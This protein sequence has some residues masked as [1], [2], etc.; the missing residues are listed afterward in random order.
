MKTFE[1]V[2]ISF[3][4]IATRIEKIWLQQ[5]SETKTIK[6]VNWTGPALTPEDAMI[7]ARDIADRI[8][9][10]AAEDSEEKDPTKAE[11]DGFW[12]AMADQANLVDFANFPNDVPSV[13]QSTFDFLLY[14]N[15]YLPTRPADVN[16]AK[17]KSKPYVPREL[18]RKIDSLEKRIANLTPRSEALDEKIHAIEAAHD[19]AEQL[20]TDMEELRRNN[21]ELRKLLGEAQKSSA[22]VENNLETT[23]K[24]RTTIEDLRSD[25]T[26]MVEES[27][28]LVAKCEENY[29][30][31]TSAG[32]AGA[33]ETRSRSLN[34]TGWV[35]VGLLAI[36]LGCAVGIGYF[37]IDAYESL[38]ANNAATS[39]ILLNL[40]VTVLGVGGPIWL[41]WLSTKN[42]GQSFKLAEDYAF[43]A[44]ISKAYEGYRKEAVNLDQAFAKQLF[45]SALTRLDELPSRFIS[46]ID[47][48]SPLQ[49]LLDNPTFQ[50]ILQKFPDLKDEIVR[51]GSETK[52]VATAAAGSLVGASTSKV[53]SNG[54]ASP[55]AGPDEES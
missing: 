5:V 36:A 35:W 52:S 6:E 17:I 14:C 9:E 21:A 8:R 26:A 16:W 30:I 44:S 39:L 55:E 24:V 33:F 31:T 15:S 12:E 34:R 11:A 41:A 29:R 50:K 46:Q 51:I 48:S 53:R 7:L 10:I 4:G 28:L 32:L 27:K 40:L 22:L 47:H 38:I 25:M 45:G 42:I 2:A 18:S 37:R 20:P 1:D 13:A 3:E 43:K 23:K 49:E 19:A 54:K